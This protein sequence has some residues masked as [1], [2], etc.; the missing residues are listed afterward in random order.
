M[1]ARIFLLLSV[2]ALSLSCGG[3]DDPK[4]IDPEKQKQEQEKKKNEEAFIDFFAD[5]QWKAYGYSNSKITWKSWG[6]SHQEFTYGI[7]CTHFGDE[8]RMDQT[9][10]GFFNKVIF[11]TKEHGVSTSFSCDP[12]K[13][14]ESYTWDIDG[15]SLFLPE[16]AM[17]WEIIA[18]DDEDF[19]VIETQETDDYP[20][21]CLVLLRY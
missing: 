2:V 7:D 19:L 9:P 12:S 8:G 17:E 13:N 10:F 15:S 1:K 11:I 21:M 14:P 18:F 16:G 5:S 6:E 3:E 20:Y 4:P